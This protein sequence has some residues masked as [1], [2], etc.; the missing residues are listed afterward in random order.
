MNN[1]FKTRSYEFDNFSKQMT[2]IS[3]FIV[4]YTDIDKKC[5]FC[6]KPAQIKHNEKDPYKIQLI[7]KECKKSHHISKSMSDEIPLIDLEQHITNPRVRH[8]HLTLSPVHINMI[9]EILAS[10]L[11]RG[12]VLSHYKI[13]R[14]VLDRIIHLYAIEID[15]DIGIKLKTTLDN[16]RKHKIKILTINRRVMNSCKSNNLSQIKLKRGLSNKDIERLSNRKV[17]AL[18]I[19]LICTGKSIPKMK[20]MC[21]IAEALNL[22]VAQIFNDYP[23]FSSIKSYTDYLTLSN[24]V[25]DDL[26]S[27]KKQYRVKDIAKMLNMPIESLYSLLSRDRLINYDDYK[28]YKTFIFN[29]KLFTFN[30]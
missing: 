11:D 19:S 30:A 12:E 9:Q 14:G 26:V 29:N 3:K 25:I 1:K 24:K 2:Y 4:K 28:K 22:S 13:S 15:E 16:N 27:M 20:T 17:K 8:A 21:Y 7:C 18:A 10:D 6:G 5:Q 23:L